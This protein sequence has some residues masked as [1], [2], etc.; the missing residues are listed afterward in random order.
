MFL[1]IIHTL[2]ENIYIYIGIVPLVR[3]SSIYLYT[4]IKKILVKLV[5]HTLLSM[6]F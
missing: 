5:I 3:S 2:G 4:S 1:R 6:K